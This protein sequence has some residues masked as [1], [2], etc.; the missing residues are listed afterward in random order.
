MFWV[1]TSEQ[2]PEDERMVLVCCLTKKGVKTYKIGYYVQDF[3]NW[4]VQGAQN[5]IAWA[6][7]PVYDPDAIEPPTLDIAIDEIRDHYRIAM[8]NQW[9]NH[10]LAWAIYQV[11]RKVDRGEMNKRK[12]G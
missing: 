6:Q 8:D 5:V 4:V 10:P 11:W 12:R 7:I 9:I 1:S 3:N 2:L